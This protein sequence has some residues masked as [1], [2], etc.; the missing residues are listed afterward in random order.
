MAS[1]TARF[2]DTNI[3]L[4]YLTRDDEE[5]ADRALAL[6]ERVERGDEQVLASPMV[7]FE[8]VYTLQRSYRVPRP[9][10]RELL[11]PILALRGLRI[12]ERR[13]YFV[14]LDIYVDHNVS[15]A[16]AFNAA[17]MVAHGTAEVYTWDTDFDRL[18]GTTRREPGE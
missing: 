8:T 2:L 5:K 14:A 11:V 16:D 13:V 4:R 12:A 9:R 1:R 10:I 15:F 3:L 18:P 7:V 17:Y 6:L